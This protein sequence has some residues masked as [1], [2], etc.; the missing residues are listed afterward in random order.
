MR[1]IILKTEVIEGELTILGL[2][3][4]SQKASGTTPRW[5]DFKEA[6]TNCL[7]PEK[8]D[9]LSLEEENVAQEILDSTGMIDEGNITYIGVDA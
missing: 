1:Y 5:I 9:L 8:C 4:L 2:V 6:K 7:D 3:E